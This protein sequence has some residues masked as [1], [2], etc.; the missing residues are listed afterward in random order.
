M[1]PWKAVAGFHARSRP[2]GGRLP[3]SG[4]LK[5][6]SE[7]LTRPEVR[8][9]T[10]TESSGPV[11]NAI[12]NIALSRGGLRRMARVQGVSPWA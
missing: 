11:M 6:T 3:L 5:R 2:A 4:R 1:A 12:G 10:L 9:E 8:T 7:R